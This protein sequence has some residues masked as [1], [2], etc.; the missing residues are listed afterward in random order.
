M[1]SDLYLPPE[2]LLN[3][4]VSIHPST[5]QD[6]WA[7]GIIAHEL[8]SQGKYPFEIT[9]LDWIKKVI[10]GDYRI[11]P[12][13]AENSNIYKIIQGILKFKINISRMK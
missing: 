7:L 8:F 13:I 3:K 4:Y 1:G 2:L 5:S 11:D 6:I 12:V 10:I 9:S